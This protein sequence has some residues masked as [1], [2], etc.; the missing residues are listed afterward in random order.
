MRR[1]NWWKIYKGTFSFSNKYEIHN[2]AKIKESQTF[3][4]KYGKIVSET[5][6][7][8]IETDKLLPH[9]CSNNFMKI[10]SS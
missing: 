1:I 8:D 6:Y 9:G 5:N 7:T 2:N 4:S 3:L 10:H